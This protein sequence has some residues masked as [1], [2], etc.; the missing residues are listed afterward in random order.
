MM[1]KNMLNMMSMRTLKNTFAEI[2]FLNQ[3]NEIVTEA[4]YRNDVLDKLIF[5]GVPVNGV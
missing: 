5:T 1:L 3:S 4:I 2:T